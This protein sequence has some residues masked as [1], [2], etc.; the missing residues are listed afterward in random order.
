VWTAA[1]VT[2]QHLSHS[3]YSH[4][5]VDVGVEANYFYHTAVALSHPMTA[6]VILIISGVDFII[7]AVVT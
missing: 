1:D 5:N 2:P 3:T 7:S 6:Y 4:E